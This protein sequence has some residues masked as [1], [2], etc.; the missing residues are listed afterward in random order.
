MSGEAP[1]MRGVRAAGTVSC[2]Y[3]GGWGHNARTCPDGEAVAYRHECI[4]VLLDDVCGFAAAYDRQSC[5]ELR[6]EVLLLLKVEVKW[7]AERK[8]KDDGKKMHDPSPGSSLATDDG[9][10]AAG[11]QEKNAAR[12]RCDTPPGV[13]RSG[14]LDVTSS[15]MKCG[16]PLAWGSGKSLCRRCM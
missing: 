13:P 7:L 15:C 11:E 10:R 5:K 1:G 9:E 3:C 8:V 6:T 14:E 16:D 2:G 4:R 12:R